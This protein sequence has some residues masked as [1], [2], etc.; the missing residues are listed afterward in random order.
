MARLIM[1]VADSIFAGT[2]GGGRGVPLAELCSVL[3][4]ATPQPP[5]NPSAQPGTGVSAEFNTEASGDLTAERFP[6]NVHRERPETRR[7]VPPLL[8]SPIARLCLAATVVAAASVSVLGVLALRPT[9]EIL[10]VADAFPNPADPGLTRA[11]VPGPDPST[12]I[13]AVLRD[14]SPHPRGAPSPGCA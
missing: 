12:G 4:L 6:E 3:L 14:V 2:P 8:Q 7:A 1:R 10:S 11:S 13:V 5:Q 9:A